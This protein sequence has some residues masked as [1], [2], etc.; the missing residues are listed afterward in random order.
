MSPLSTA[1][2]RAL[3]FGLCCL[4]ACCAFPH[5]Q[6]ARKIKRMPLAD[7]AQAS[8]EDG[9]MRLKYLINCALPAGVIVETEADGK[10]YEFPG[11]LGLA[12]EWSQRALTAEES[13]WVSACILARTNYFGREVK[14]SIRADPAPAG[15]LTADS[16]E[17]ARFPLHEAGFFGNIFSPDAPA[18]V[19]IGDESPQRESPLRA[20]YRICS[21]P[22]GRHLDD[23]RA[24]SYCNFIVTESCSTRPFVQGGVDY[25]G[26]VVHIYLQLPR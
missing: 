10:R 9:R 17:R 14:I 12:S 20:L 6:A 19:C 23:G 16:E 8:T 11:D 3:F 22:D 1:L 5:A 13:R 15:R 21:L 4:C 2:R 18:Y 7:P 26:Q 25:S 24:L